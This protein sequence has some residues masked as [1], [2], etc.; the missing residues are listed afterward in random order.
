MG[1]YK[2][3]TANSITLTP[4]PF[5]REMAMEAYLYENPEI[6]ALDDGDLSTVS[7]LDAEVDLEDGRPSRS[8]DGRIDLVAV[9]GESYLAIIELKNC[10]LGQAHLEQLEDYLKNEKLI[11]DIVTKY[12]EST[13]V[14]IIGILV[15]TSM[16]TGLKEKIESG[17]MINGSIPCA[18]IV[19]NRFR[20]QDS[21]I[22]VLTDVIFRNTSRNYDKTKYRYDNKIFAKN[23]LVLEII[24]SY[25]ADN[26]TV[27]YAELCRVFPKALQ[28]S[29]GCFVTVE[30]AQKRWDQSGYRRHF[31]KPDEV[32]RLSDTTISVTTQWGIQNIVRFVQRANELNYNI[33][34]RI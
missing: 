17:Y 8:K 11:R 6:L 18:A 20:G 26:P 10:E 33:E 25:V 1:L 2:H 7:I 34:K 24:R 32:I 19:L 13:E 29:L 12:I 27:S 15:G 21:N 9:Y 14:S 4:M 16:N 5:M 23:R 3:L 31:L 28:G 22:Y 30:E